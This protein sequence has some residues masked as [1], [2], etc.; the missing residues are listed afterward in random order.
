[1]FLMNQM[2]A[3]FVG[4]PLVESIK[5]DANLKKMADGRRLIKR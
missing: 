4:H 1:M 5:E 2:G 3:R